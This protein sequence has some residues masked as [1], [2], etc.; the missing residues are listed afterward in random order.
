M[1]G[2]R[3]FN[4]QSAKPP[5]GQVHLN[6]GADL[7][8]RANGKDIADD[9]HPDHQRRIDRGTARVGIIRCEFS[10]HPVQI[11]DRIDLAHQ[12]ISSDDI[13][14]LELVEKLTLAPLLPSHHRECLRH[15]NVKQRNHG[16]QSNSTGVLQ[17]YQVICGQD[18]YMRKTEK[19]T[20]RRHER[21]HQSSSKHARS[22]L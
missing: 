20:R 11:K 5:I 21:A 22:L 15:Q 2:D 18:S 4:R 8:F 17:Q 1:I 16:S 12:M 6:L 13:V 3:F 14:Q 19:I 10:V 9:E 7:T